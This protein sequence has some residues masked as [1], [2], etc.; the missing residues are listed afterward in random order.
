MKDRRDTESFEIYGFNK[1]KAEVNLKL[2]KI[3]TL[4][5]EVAALSSLGAVMTLGLESA[6]LK[7]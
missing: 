2:S 1:S 7:V 3:M 5:E 4:E 6:S